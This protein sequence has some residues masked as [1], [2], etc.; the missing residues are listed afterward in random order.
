MDLFTQSPLDMQGI[1]A[2]IICHHLSINVITKPVIRKKIN[3]RE[4]RRINVVKVKKLKEER[5]ISEIKYP[6]QLVNI[7]MVKKSSNKWMCMNF[8]DINQC[9][10]NTLTINSNKYRLVNDSSRDKMLSLMYDQSIYNQIKINTLDELKST[11]MTKNY[12]YYYKI[13]TFQSQEHRRR[14]SKIDGC[15][16]RRLNKEQ[17]RSLYRLHGS[18]T[19]YKKNH[20]KDLKDILRFFKKYNICIN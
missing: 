1:D 18:K 5:L 15:G 10:P 20:Y 12:Y 11:F 4:E 13:M 19:P 14:P 6:T 16:N 8:T 2:D 7:V 3:I 17:S 9:M